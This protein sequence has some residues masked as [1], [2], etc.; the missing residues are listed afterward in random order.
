[1]G[2]IVSVVSG[3]GLATPHAHIFYDAISAA[4]EYEKQTI[5][6]KKYSST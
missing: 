4:L 5:I 1:M 3:T 2:A 6:K